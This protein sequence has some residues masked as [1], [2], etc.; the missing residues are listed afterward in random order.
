MTRAAP[1]WLSTQVTF[2]PL[3]AASRPTAPDPAYKSR[4]ARPA[5]CWAGSRSTTP[6]LDAI[7]AKTDSLTRS[8]VGRVDSPGGVA[9]RREAN[10]PAIILLTTLD[11]VKEST[12]DRQ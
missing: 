8:V 1:L 4:K 7:W 5:N 10:L 6:N 9:T 12:H 11:Y 3:L 2:A